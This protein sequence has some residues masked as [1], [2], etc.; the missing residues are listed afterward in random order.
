VPID[1][2]FFSVHSSS[3]MTGAFHVLPVDVLATANRSVFT[4]FASTKDA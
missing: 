3:T 4:P 2:C 1:D